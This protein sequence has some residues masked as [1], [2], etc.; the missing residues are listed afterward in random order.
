MPALTWPE[1]YWGSAAALAA[2]Y[3]AMFLVARGPVSLRLGRLGW[4][5]LALAGMRLVLRGMGL[6]FQNSVDSWLVLVAAMG[7]IVLLVEQ[8]IWFIRVERDDLCQQIRQACRGLFLTCE[9]TA[10]GQFRL[11]AKDHTYLLGTWPL[12]RRV[13]RLRLP[14]AAGPGKVT[15]L[16]QWLA[17]QFPG[18]VPRVRIVV[19]R[20][21]S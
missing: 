20:S 17:K 4:P 11:T 7:A 6:P 10:P 12:C 14:V 13:Q 16:V 2:A 3:V 15:L 1:I 21:A 9:E 19:H 18:P 5:V 8:H